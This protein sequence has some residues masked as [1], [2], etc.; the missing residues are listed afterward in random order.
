MRSKRCT[1]GWTVGLGVTVAALLWFV[2]PA[3]AIPLESW[4][5]QIQ[6]AGM[7][8]KVLT[9]FGGAAVLDKETQLVWE[10]SPSASFHTWFDARTACLNLTVGG[11][12]GWRLPAIAELAS[13]VDPSVPYP[14]PTLFP[15][16]PFLNFELGAFWSASTDA[17]SPSEPGSWPST[18]A[19]WP[20]TLRTSSSI[21]GVY[22]VA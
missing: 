7:R 3:G 21:S 22:A 16:H 15:G 1:W 17:R 19:P 2:D 12:K 13:L 9:E 14:G 6:R 18:V 5:N 20:P 4:D 8:F 10:R 11:R